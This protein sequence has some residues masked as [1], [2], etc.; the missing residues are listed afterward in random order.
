MILA[1]A[2]IAVATAMIADTEGFDIVAVAMTAKDV[3]WLSTSVGKFYMGLSWMGLRFFSKNCQK[4]SMT[5]GQFSNS[6]T[7]Y[8]IIT[9]KYK[10]HRFA[11]HLVLK[12]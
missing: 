2:A 7:S 3:G 6:S 11:V 1:M 4:V 10:L 9:K 5:F 12:L 8:P